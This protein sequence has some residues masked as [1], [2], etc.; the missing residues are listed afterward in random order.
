MK[1]Y[2]A[3]LL[4]ALTLAAEA[5]VIWNERSYGED[6]KP[7]L[8]KRCVNKYGQCTS[9][10][11]CCDKEDYANRKLRCLTQCDEGGCLSYKQCMFYAGIQK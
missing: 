2:I 8:H 9:D 6:Q 10:S 4:V 7:V 11:Q 5:N 3:I 1:L